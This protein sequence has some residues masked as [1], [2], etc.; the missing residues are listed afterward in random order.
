[1][2][3]GSLC[4]YKSEVMKDKTLI[5]KLSRTQDLSLNNSLTIVK[6]GT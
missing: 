6:G 1:M 2:M 5:L 4:R 3:G